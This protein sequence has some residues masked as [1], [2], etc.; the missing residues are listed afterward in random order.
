M[1]KN[2]TILVIYFHP[3]NNSLIDHLAT[4]KY[5]LK[6]VLETSVSWEQ[7]TIFIFEKENLR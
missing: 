2:E 5:D 1:S 7:I 4:L 6:A 3:R